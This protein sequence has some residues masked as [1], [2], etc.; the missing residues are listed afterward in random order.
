MVRSQSSHDD[1]SEIMR[2]LGNLEAG[3]KHLHEELQAI[4]SIA[5]QNRRD[6]NLAK[7]GSAFATFAVAC[8][9]VVAYFR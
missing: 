8:L 9:G 7:G 3:Q 2:V 6:I 5:M 1:H 4:K